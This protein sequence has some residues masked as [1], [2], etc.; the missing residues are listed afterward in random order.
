M[1]RYASPSKVPSENSDHECVGMVGTNRMSRQGMEVG[2]CLNIAYWGKG[3][4]TE[5]LKAFLEIYWELPGK[6]SIYLY[7]YIFLLFF[8]FQ[9]YAIIFFSISRR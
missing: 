1:Y 7:I 9:Q 4:A 3:F 2:Y 6:L 8:F 5:G